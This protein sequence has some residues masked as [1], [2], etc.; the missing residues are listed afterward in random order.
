[1]ATILDNNGC[2]CHKCGKN[3]KM[4]L[5]VSDDLW[6]LITPSKND[7]GGLLCPTCIIQSVERIGGFCAFKMEAL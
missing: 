2:T 1:M 5:M 7:Q 3:Y 6:K 4:D